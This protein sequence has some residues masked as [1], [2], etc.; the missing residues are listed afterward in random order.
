MAGAMT[1]IG[2]NAYIM[3]CVRKD[4]YKW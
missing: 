4:L 2:S 3:L 1:F